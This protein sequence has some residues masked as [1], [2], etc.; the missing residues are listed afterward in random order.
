LRAADARIDLQILRRLHEERDAFDIARGIAQPF[1][2]FFGIRALIVRLE[3]D[4]KPGGIDGRVH[5]SRADRGR[6]ARDVRVAPD[7]IGNGV[8]ALQHRLEGNVLRGIR[9]A[10]DHPSILL[11]QQPFRHDDVEEDGCDQRYD[12]DDQNEALMGEHPAQPAFIQIA[13][14]RPVF[15]GPAIKRALVFSIFFR[16]GAQ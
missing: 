9:H 12:S 16:F 11:R 8:H 5:C 6:H 7:D 10:D 14:P 3:H 15:F 1:D 4:V 2:D 13:K